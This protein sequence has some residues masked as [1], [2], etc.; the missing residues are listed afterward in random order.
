MA[1]S[2]NTI[3]AS[4]LTAAGDIAVSGSGSLTG[5][6]T[7]QGRIT[8]QEYHSEI[9]SASIL[10][11][12]GSTK[13]GDSAD[14]THQ[15][16]GSVNISGSILVNG[17]AAVGPQGATGSQG[18]TG[19]QG[20]TGFQ[21]ATGIQGSIGPQGNQGPIGPQGATGTQGATGAQGFQGATGAQ[22]ATGTAN[23]NG[24]GFVKADGTTISYDNSTYLTTS[25]AGTTYVPYTGA[26]SSLDVGTN[27]LSGRYLNANGSAGL[28]GVLHLKQD[29]AYLARGNGYSTI[30]S[31]GILFQFFAYTGASTYKD[32]ALRYDGLTDNTTRI[33]SLPDASG[34]LALT[35][36][37]S[38]YLPLTGGTLTGQLDGTS[39]TFSG[40]VLGNGE[41]NYIGM[42]AT[43]GAP[44]LGFVKLSGAQPFLAFAADPFTIKISSG[45]TIA[46]SNTFSNVLHIATS[47]AATF[48]GSV[49]TTGQLY[50]ASGSN[51]NIGYRLAGTASGQTQWLLG[52][53]GT[54]GVITAG[55]FAI[56]NETSGF[57]P[58]TIESTGTATFS[59]G[60]VNIEANET[61]L[62]LF[63]TYAVGMNARARI[64]A[65]GAGGGSGYGG[66]FRVST[67][68][69]NNVWNTD[70]FIVNS[71]GNVGIGTVTNLYGKLSVEA[72]GNHITM[73]APGATAGKYWALDVSSANQ[74]YI[75][76]NAG[77]Q[78]LT[79]TDAGAATFTSNI[80]G[81]GNLE[82]VNA[83]GP[84][85]LVGEGVGVNE[86]AAVDWDATNNRLRIA[87][88]PFAFGANGGQIT[89]NTDGNVGIRVTDLGPDGLS[90]STTSNYSWSEGSG[91]AYAVL[92]RQRNSAAT[93]MASGYK[94]SNTG[95]FASSFGI[96]MSRAAI[97]VGYNNGSIAF[98][99]DS[100][101]NVANGTDISPSERLTIINN[102]KVGIG[103]I[104][105]DNTYQGLTIKGTDP[106]LRLKTTSGSGW[107]WT[108]YVTSAGVNN[109]SMGV[110][111]TLP[112]FGIKAGAG[113]DNPNFVM[114]TSGNIGIGTTFPQNRLTVNSPLRSDGETNSLGAA[115]VAGPISDFPSNDFTNSTAIFRVQGTN[116]TNSLQFGIGNDT[117]AF[118]PWIQ[119]S[120]DNST[121]GSPNIGSK[122]I[123]LNPIG[124]NVGIGLINPTA[125]LQ[126]RGPNATGVFFDAQN[127]G[128]GGA[129]FSR[130][131][132]STFPFNQYTFANG[133][134]GIG[135]AS[136]QQTLSVEGSVKISR[137]IYSW[138]QSGSNAWDGFSFL[139][140]KTNLHAGLGGNTE[141]TM[142]LFYARLYSYAGQIKEG[143]L[144]FHNWDGSFFA[145]TTTGNI[146]SGPYR[147]SDGFVVLVLSISSSSHTGV[148]VD[149]HQAFPYGFRDRIVTAVS[150]SN[151]SGGVY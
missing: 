5:D 117:Y 104:S 105:P 151:N 102:G 44:R 87:T 58:L 30:A 42:D 129:T 123:L 79:I 114:S 107:V 74:F 76:N 140:L 67:R 25:S 55:G 122:S 70:V 14:D 83:G 7:V 11:T 90:L 119:G 49:T 12:S 16:T 56:R 100:A 103:E 15:F 33:Y 96:S 28:G 77:T 37:L 6:L 63:S 141:H 24:T 82:L 19:I 137:T 4:L 106:S 68:A 93:V 80:R 149:W 132:A 1:K 69:T 130:I 13:F 10:Y 91:N 144:G 95:S 57:N 145:T 36:N 101:T 47:G 2:K 78:Y 3:L 112:Y 48:A 17:V 134:V 99:S 41:G 59:G 72:P 86:Y 71:V 66:D 85:L 45:S 118:N 53:S 150:P 116:S 142:S 54:G 20:S 81:G 46:T 136:P 60:D 126:V 139:H 128:A 39:A 9:V 61:Y 65:V 21:G 121:P 64:R 27:D 120:F 109:F 84:Y 148:T 113:L 23:I 31:S 124:G 131:N 50:I 88:Q 35:S 18:A 22:G 127:D 146:W 29:A 94:R 111:Q 147:S 40:N 73:R 34:T 43:G 133:N 125:I 143:H 110:N 32:F 51:I 135:N 75:I 8:A 97:A 62:N 98:F 138:Y 115:V 89:L 38:S 26:T 108:E 92:F 52:S